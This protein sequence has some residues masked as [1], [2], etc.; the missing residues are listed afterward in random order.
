MAPRDQ[1]LSRSLV[2]LVAAA[3]LSSHSPLP[4][5][6]MDSALL[7]A[8]PTVLLAAATYSGETEDPTL[9]T[10]EATGMIADALFPDL[11]PEGFLPEGL[12][13]TDAM[14]RDIV[15]ARGIGVDSRPDII[16]DNSDLLRD[17]LAAFAASALATALLHPLDTVK[18]RLQSGAYTVEPLCGS[19]GCVLGVPMPE[20]PRLRRRRSS[21]PDSD[22]SDDSDD[23]ATAAYASSSSSLPRQR[24]YTN[25]YTGFLANVAK[26]A[27]DAAVYLA[28]YESFSQARTLARSPLATRHSP[29]ATR[30][31]PLNHAPRHSPPYS[32]P[33][34][35]LATYHSPL[36]THYPTHHSQPYPP[37]TTLPTTHHRTHQALLQD[38][39]W[40][41]HWLLAVLVAGALGDA[42]GSVLR[43]PAEVV[44]KRLQTGAS[45]SVRA[46]GGT[47]GGLLRA[48]AAVC[49]V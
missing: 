31:S 26:E 11:L 14:L 25:V 39:W 49:G 47:G 3:L 36:A 42:C 27:P 17:G 21:K 5:A 1:P 18:C 45:P 28:L 33:T 13:P 10:M 46:T 7:G 9:P 23:S 32:P 37:L 34:T 29:L 24:L 48:R 40:S 30:H 41:S 2:A 44:A 16:A 20:L 43:L 38:A 12:L 15:V 19:G 8:S 4:S 6:A 35:L 22:D